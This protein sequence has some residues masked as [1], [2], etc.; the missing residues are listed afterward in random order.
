MN[1]A[2]TLTFAE[3]MK[4]L[5]EGNKIRGIPWMMIDTEYMFVEDGPCGSIKIKTPSEIKEPRAAHFNPSIRYEIFEAKVEVTREQV[6]AA[7]R[8]ANFNQ[9]QAMDGFV[10]LVCKELGL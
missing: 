9:V 1:E 7:L 10:N 4:A 8:S 6:E 5:A 3:A 2:K